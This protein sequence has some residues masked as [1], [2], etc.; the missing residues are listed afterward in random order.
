MNLHLFIS[1]VHHLIE[2]VPSL[3]LSISLSAQVTGVLV[4]TVQ[5]GPGK[6][7]FFFIFFLSV[8][9]VNF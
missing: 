7:K 2:P 4:Y 5:D 6:D 8:T 1:T 9:K 3:D